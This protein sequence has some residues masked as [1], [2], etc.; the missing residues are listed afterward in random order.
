MV[1]PFLVGLAL[2]SSVARP[3][4][5]GLK[6]LRSSP[7]AQVQ[8][9]LLTNRQLTRRDLF[10]AAVLTAVG[11]VVLMMISR[12]VRRFW[13]DLYAS[14]YGDCRLGRQSFVCARS[15]ARSATG[16]MTTDPARWAPVDVARRGDSEGQHRVNKLLP[17]GPKAYEASLAQLSH[18]HR[19]R[20]PLRDAG[21]HF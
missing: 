18:S 15:A 14:D 13:V 9:P 6:P 2:A 11:P 19:G 8:H 17:D 5:A 16:A 4:E 3:A 10:Q 7:S 21:V 20:Q 12:Y 1:F